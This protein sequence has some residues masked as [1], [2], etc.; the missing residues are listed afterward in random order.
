MAKI[1]SLANV[2]GTG[3]VVEANTDFYNGLLALKEA[4]AHLITPR[5]EM[6][7]RMVTDGKE[8]I[9]K[10]CGTWTAA[11]FEYAKRSDVLLRLNS[12]LIN[13]RLAEKV[14]EANRQRSYFSSTDTRFYDKT[15]EQ[16]EQDKN[17]APEERKILILPSR[18]TF[19]IT[20]Q[21]NMEVL[22]FL[23]RSSELAKQYFE[24]NGSTP[25]TTY[26]VNNDVVNS[27]DG[28]LMTQLWLCGR[29]GDDR[30]GL[31]GLSRDL[32]DSGR[33]HGVRESGQTGEASLQKVLPYTL[34]E[35]EKYVKIVQGV[36]GG[37][38]P[39]SRLEQVATFLGKLGVK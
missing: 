8:N 23:L 4:G 3:E 27:Q 39:A 7:A 25:I 17:K 20:P 14:V 18:T 36:R 19:Q 9:G 37:K 30:S 1:T 21:N 29:G 2:R 22:N 16:A 26:L 31:D 6:R 13:P 11:G 24:F 35:V 28:T 34:R 32:D 15:A 10:G 38:L 33:V 5:N 12:R